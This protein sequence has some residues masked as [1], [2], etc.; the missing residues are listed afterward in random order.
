M[1]TSKSRNLW[2]LRFQVSNDVLVKVLQTTRK[3]LEIF[4]P[5]VIILNFCLVLILKM[6]E[7]STSIVLTTWNKR[8]SSLNIW[9]TREYVLE[10]FN[11][12]VL[13]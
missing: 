8:E 1:E 10:I 12:N 9:N 2:N 5:N 13:I 7:S 4:H 3:L 6:F 11:P